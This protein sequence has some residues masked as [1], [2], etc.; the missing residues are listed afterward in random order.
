[1]NRH[2]Q[3]AWQKYGEAAF[4]FGVLLRC[5]KS[6]VLFY[7][8]RAIDVYCPEYNVCRTA[9]NTLGQIF[10]AES[11]L[12]M[13]ETAKLKRLSAEH[14]RKISE[15]L[16]VRVCT[17]ETRKKLSEASSRDSN[18]FRSMSLRGE[19]NLFQGKKHTDETK[20]KL[21]ELAKNRTPEHQRKINE[22]NKGRIPA[23][24]GT[25]GLVFMSEETKAKM[26][27]SH[28]RY[29]AQRKAA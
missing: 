17:E 15:S 27:E 8:Q 11:R 29:F 12:K 20:R 4:S 14:K 26:V 3:S 23:N 16:R 13:S 9:G 7:E 18:F 2:L 19:P 21:S 24:K 5:D 22:A 25:K 10:S 28:K 1:M 6:H